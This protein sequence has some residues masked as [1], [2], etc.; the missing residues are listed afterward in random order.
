VSS[1]P[2][3]GAFGL[4]VG[5]ASSHAHN[6]NSDNNQ[7]QSLGYGFSDIEIKTWLQVLH[8]LLVFS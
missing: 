4:K 3:R 1:K 5:Y 8:L 7:D 6:N 2:S